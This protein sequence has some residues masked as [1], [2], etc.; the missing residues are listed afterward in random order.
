MRTKLTKRQ[1]EILDYIKD[2]MVKEE[3]CPSYTDIGKKFG[4]SPTAA[5]D[6]VDK[7]IKKGHLA[8]S[9]YIKGAVNKP[10]EEPK[11]FRSD[12]LSRI[13]YKPVM[14][15]ACRDVY[16]IPVYNKIEK[17]DPY[18]KDNNI[19]CL[20]PLPITKIE[21]IKDIC[22]GFMYNSESMTALGFIPGDIVIAKE[23]REGNV[24]DVIYVN[25]SGKNVLRKMFDVGTHIVLVSN[26]AGVEPEVYRWDDV[27]IICQ[28]VGIHRLG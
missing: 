14:V 23:T 26:N 12:S 27:K 3:G 19:E 1:Q 2:R 4:F 20:L 18:L 24:G 6:H 7:I 9:L 22:F 15:E 16:E 11:I 28:C 8:A 17:K 13:A 21:Y 5:R 25:V 10:I